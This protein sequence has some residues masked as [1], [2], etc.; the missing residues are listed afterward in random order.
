MPVPRPPLA[1]ALILAVSA[2]SDTSLSRIDDDVDVDDDT[3]TPPG[4]DDTTPPDVEDLCDGTDDDGDGLVDEGYPDTDG[5]GIADCVDTACDLDEPEPGT[6]EQ[7]EACEGEVFA[8]PDPWDVVVEWRWAGTAGGIVDVYGVPAVAYLEDT[9]GNGVPGP[10]DLPSV[11]LAAGLTSG[12]ASAVVALR[13]DG[14][15]LWELPGSVSRPISGGQSPGIGDVDGDGWPDVVVFETRA[16]AALD[17]TGAVIWRTAIDSN[18]E[19]PTAVIA[20]LDGDGTPEVVT[21]TRVFDG[22]T[23]AELATHSPYPAAAVAV[24]DLDGDGV[25]EIVMNGTAYDWGGTPLWTTAAASEVWPGAAI[26]NVDDDPEAE[27]V[28]S[29]GSSV[30]LVEHDGTVTWSQSGTSCGG[31]AIADFDGDGRAEIAA[32]MGTRLALIEGDGTVLWEAP[33]SDASGLASASAA[34]LD[35][36]GLPEVLHADEDCF[37]ILDG[38]TGGTRHQDCA[39]GGGTLWEYP[40]AADVDGDGAAEVLVPSNEW[41][42][43]P[44]PGLTVYGHGGTGWTPMGVTWAANAFASGM[45]TDAGTPLPAGSATWLAE[46]LFRARGTLAGPQA[47]LRATVWDVCAV[48]CPDGVMEVAVQVSNHGFREAPAGTPVSLYS[49]TGGVRTLLATLP[50]GEPVPPGESSGPLVFLAPV[51]GYG[52]GLVAIADDPGTGGWGVNAECDEDNNEAWWT[53]PPCP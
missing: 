5:D 6:V 24:G 47:D 35:G 48:A 46:G 31:A 33:I 11:V 1:F 29:T 51:Q 27:V 9:D 39:M 45:M 25:Q 20:D 2:C 44:T 10:G 38:A 49:E 16:V 21:H 53:E 43:T 17:R 4:D 19:Y 12:A 23:G 34:D 40:V 32:P 30:H 15:P 52:E 28:V 3:T 41:G 14:S 13:G 18:E 7:V 37:R 36:D 50:L 26:G 22:P 8:V 42:Q